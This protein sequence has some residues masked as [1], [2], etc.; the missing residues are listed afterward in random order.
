[1]NVRA[2][3]GL[4]LVAASGLAALYVWGLTG[5]PAFGDFGGHYTSYLLQHAVAERRATNVVTAIVFD[6]RGIDT[7]GEEFILFSSVMAVAMLL[8]DVRAEDAGRP[9][10]AAS[11]DAL[12]ITGLALVGLV[13]TLGIWLVAHGQ[14]TPGGGFQGGVVIASA[15]VLVFC[16]ASY[17]AYRAVSP[18]RLVDL[19]EGVGAAGFAAVGL[20]ALASGSSFLANVL[21]L[22]RHGF[23]DSGGTISV[24]NALVGLE[25]ATAFVLLFTAFLE[26]LMDLEST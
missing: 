22:G 18:T 9:R 7:L 2:R 25:V 6:Y 26:H 17:N 11:G 12:R 19:G 3:L 23:I 13:V 20:A 10:L 4:F 8:R 21:P 14:V 16:S 1:M 5:L 15:L 24:I